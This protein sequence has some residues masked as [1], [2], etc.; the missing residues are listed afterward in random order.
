MDTLVVT[1][2]ETT[3]ITTS[4]MTIN[5]SVD[6][7][8]VSRF[9]I[10]SGTTSNPTS[11]VSDSVGSSTRSYTLTG[12]NPNT[13]YYF[14]V[15]AK[16]DGT[17]TQD[18]DMAV[19]SARTNQLT[20]LYITNLSASAISAKSMTVTWSVSGSPVANYTL[21]YGSTTITVGAGETSRRITGLSPNTQYTITLT[22]NGVEGQSLS[23]SPSTI[24]PRTI[25]TTGLTVTITQTNSTPDSVTFS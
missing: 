6:P 21:Q 24:T 7:S 11:V 15:L 3:N 18:S 8:Q 14:G 5:W 10:Y 17:S 9:I 19:G 1:I 16:G 20:Q 12:L 13:T 4:S 2:E 23:S 25:A 22:A